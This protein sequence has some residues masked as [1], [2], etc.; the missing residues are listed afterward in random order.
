SEGSWAIVYVTSNTKDAL[1][2]MVAR[3]MTP[4]S[5]IPKTFGATKINIPKAPALGLL[6]ENPVFSSYNK[7]AKDNGRD[8][9]EFQAYKVNIEE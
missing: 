1:I 5:L 2:V 9:I 3:T 4:L 7:R 8:L 6:L